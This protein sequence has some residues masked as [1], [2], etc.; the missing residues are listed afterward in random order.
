MQE[1]TTLPNRGA[2]YGAHLRSSAVVAVQFIAVA[3]ALWVLAWVVGKAWV[4]LLPVVLALIV[5]TVL[6]PPVRWLRGKGVPP[7]AAVL[8]ILLVALG[9]LSGLVAAVAPAIV[10]QSTELAQQATAGVVQVRDWLG[11][12]PLDISEAQLDSAVTAITDRLNSSSAQIA[13]GVFTGVGAATSALVTAFTAIV[14]TFFL[15]KDGPRFIPW[16]RRTVGNPAAPHVAEVLERVWST[17]GGF[18]RTQALVSLVDAVLIGAGLVILGVPLA[19]ALAIITFIGGFVPIVG[20]FVAGGLAVLIALVSNG[21]VDA[22][23]VL[24]I[25]L[26]VQQLEGNV[27]QPWLQSKSMKLHAVIVLLAVT[28]GA[29]TFGVIGAFLAVPVAAAAAV[30]IRYYDEQVSARSG[31]TPASEQESEEAEESA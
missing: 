12:P 22:L 30:I 9:L 14:V 29:S 23:I 27:L 26:A 8:L 16:L 13:S 3:A 24:G 7:A 20:A 4:I 28:L 31:E 19:Y 1:Q 18:I 10:E 6:W 11:G 25:I 5:C 21:P 17:L 2:V 15:L